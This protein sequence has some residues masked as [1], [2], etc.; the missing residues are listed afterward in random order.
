MTMQQAWHTA[1]SHARG[2]AQEPDTAMHAPI[3]I[4]PVAPERKHARGTP[5]RRLRR[6]NIA[7]LLLALL[8]SGS[9]TGGYYAMYRI[10]PWQTSNGMADAILAGADGSNAIDPADTATAPDTSTQVHP[11]EAASAR[12]VARRVLHGRVEQETIA[13]S[14]LPG[15]HPLLIYLPPGYDGSRQRYPVLYLLHGA[16]GA[17]TDWQKAAGIDKTMDALITVGRVQPMIVVMPDGNGGPF[18]DTEWANNGRDVRAEDYLTQEV[19]P[20]IDAHYRTIADRDHRAIGGLSTGGYGA[21]NIALHHP[22]LF[23]YALGLSGNYLATGTWTGQD[24][25]Y[26]N[27]DVKRFNSPLLYAPQLPLAARESL[28]IY[29]NVDPHDSDNNTAQQTRQFDTLLTELQVPHLTQYFDGGHSWTY[30][31]THIVDAL[32]YLQAAMPKH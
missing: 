5:H 29:L 4:T 9:Y 26:G 2:L 31:K 11:S 19:V 6:R 16:P 14:L 17:F 30:W 10:L 28:H 8:A 18:S 24:I 3:Q 12:R 13:S 32:Q 1:M 20:Y 27:D 25:W 15:E 7:L 23:G 22:D 21:V